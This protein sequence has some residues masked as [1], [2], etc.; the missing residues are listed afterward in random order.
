[1]KLK[2]VMAIRKTNLAERNPLVFQIN[3]VNENAKMAK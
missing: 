2:T 1:M 3:W